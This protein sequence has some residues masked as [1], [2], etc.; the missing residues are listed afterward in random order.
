MVARRLLCAASMRAATLLLFVSSLLLVLGCGAASGLGSTEATST[1]AGGR[2]SSDTAAGGG[3]IGAGGSTDATGG[4]IGAGGGIGWVGAVGTYTSCGMGIDTSNGN[5]FLDGAGILDM[6]SLTL[7]EDGFVL[8]VTYV[9]QGGSTTSLTFTPVTSFTAKLSN[10]PVLPDYTGLCVQGPG[11][12]GGFPATFAATSG[13]LVYE[14]DTLF[15]ELAGNLNGGE[16]T[17]CGAQAG[18]GHTWI[19]CSNSPGSQGPPPAPSPAPAFPVGT[20]AC[21][22]AIGAFVQ[23]NGTN[24]FATTGSNEMNGVL[25]VTQSGGTVVATYSNDDTFLSGSLDFTIADTA[26]ALA[27]LG[28]SLLAPCSEPITIPPPSGPPQ[29]IAISAATLTQLDTTLLLTFSGTAPACDNAEVKGG[30]VCT[31]M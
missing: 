19:I 26:T 20:Y 16:Q 1:G 10:A 12:E 9:D 7:A 2:A 25:T 22:S 14:N 4:A 21:N 8:D 15:V 18:A 5:L 6:G 11:D 17:P 31:S 30:L 3:T 28:Q 29:P 13:A 24:D 27:P 23:A